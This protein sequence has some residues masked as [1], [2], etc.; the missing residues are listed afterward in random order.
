M[1]FPLPYK[2][3][4]VFRVVGAMGTVD[5]RISLLIH[6]N[7]DRK[8]VFFVHFAMTTILNW[9]WTQSVRRK[10][11]WKR[12]LNIIPLSLQ[13]DKDICKKYV[14]FILVGFDSNLLE[15]LHI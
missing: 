14:T 11:V 9:D 4:E 13:G 1:E 8:T 12:Y 2:D 3:E 5:G 15:S 7:V 10:I 6:P